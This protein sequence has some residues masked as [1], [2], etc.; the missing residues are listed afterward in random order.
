LYIVSAKRGNPTT[1]TGYATVGGT[2]AAPVASSPVASTAYYFDNGSV[3]KTQRPLDLA[4]GRFTTQI[5]AFNFG[6]C[7]ANR[8]NTTTAQDALGHASSTVTDCYTEHVLSTIDPNTARTCFQYDGIGRL[9]ETALP[10]DLLTALPLQASGVAGSS[11]AYV[12]DT[13]SCITTSGSA[14]GGG[15]GGP[16]TWTTY[17]P[18]GLNNVSY[19][20]ARTV[21]AT[22]D[23]TSNGHVQ[24]QFVDGR[25]R[26]IQHCS[27]VDPNTNGGSAAVCSSTVYDHMGRVQASYVP[28][29][30][31]ALPTAVV[32]T[33]A[34]DQYT[35]TQ[36][37]GLGRVTSAQLMVA[38]VGVLPA[39]RSSY[40][41]A[42]GLFVN[43]VY[44]ANN[45]QSQSK[46]DV[47]GRAV[48]HDVQNNTCGST[49]TWLATTLQYDAVGR[50]GT[51]IDPLGNVS[52]IVY[53]GLSRKT[54]VS[55][56]DRGIWHFVYDNNNNLIQQTDARGAV[57]NLH[58]DPLNRVTLR[59]LPYHK[60]GTS[61][62]G[63]TPGEEDEVT[64]YD[65]VANQPATCYSCDDH[66]ST[67]TD[68]CDTATL[69]CTHTGTA[70]T[71]PDQ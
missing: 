25:V 13:S 30:A 57:I 66:C 46:N 5:T 26:G 69:V 6:P 65:S 42:G 16:T 48:E 33:P 29:Y 51:V 35:L 2:L 59:D 24:V 50:L 32:A 15:G 37:D 9:V 11:S 44:D 1:V 64:Y 36:Y 27:E 60:N 10:G 70:C 3:Q 22:R 45:C 31:S 7:A 49:P 56:P 23:G 58:Y 55:D 21:T 53:D 20:Q 18:Y 38:G 4:A 39:T 47:L 43:T 14:V 28:F 54:Q 41:S 19:N 12:R 17:Y 34:A 71:W 40:S 61:W 52:G 8:T 63:G 67:T 68:N 62:V